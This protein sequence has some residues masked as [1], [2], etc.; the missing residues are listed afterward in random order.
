MRER[1]SDVP[2]A[3][4]TVRIDT[5]DVD[6]PVGPA[7]LHVH[8]VSRPKALVVLGHGA[9]RGSDTADL[10]GLA[11]ALPQA[12]VSVVLVDQPWVLAGRRVATAPATLDVAWVAALAQVRAAA[13][14][15]RRVP[16]VAGGRSAGARVACRTAEAVGAA[17]VLALAFPLVPPASRASADKHRAALGKRRPELGAPLA[18]GVP[19]VVVQ[20]ESDVFGG[21]SEL[22]DV[23]A[24]LAQGARTAA[25]TV[26]VP[27]ADHSLLV[28]R[29]GLDPAAV[30][31]AAAL[32]AVELGT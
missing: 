9:G 31:L 12:G 32:L 16:L 14:S 13:G 23:L 22:A 24:D 3:P 10:L 20:G 5:V 18:A 27:G 21:A 15:S 29:G 1:C 11:Q 19:L 17:A 6:T 28:R 25:E 4:R 26:A 30:L 8:A 2:R 7:R